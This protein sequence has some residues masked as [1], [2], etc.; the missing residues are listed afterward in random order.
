[1]PRYAIRALLLLLVACL[2]ALTLLSL[3]L[4]GVIHFHT[5]STTYQSQS[6]P[7]TGARSSTTTVDWSNW[8]IAGLTLVGL[9]V[10]VWQAKTNRQ[11]AV[12]QVSYDPDPHGYL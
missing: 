3:L 1:M 11:K 9:G 2:A 5:T 10:T 4:A 7:L 12:A 8:V 6:L